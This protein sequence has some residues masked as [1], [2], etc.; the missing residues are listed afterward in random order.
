MILQV[1]KH[2]VITFWT[3]QDYATN[4]K[5]MNSPFIN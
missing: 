3:F 2:V 5:S 1:D 4:R